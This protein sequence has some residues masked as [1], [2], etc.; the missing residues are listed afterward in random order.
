MHSAKKIIVI[1]GGIGGAAAAVSL[2][3][4]GFEPVVYER[5]K[6]LREV[7]AGIA[8]WANATHVLKKLDLLE[9]ALRVG[10]VTSNYQFNSQSGKELVNVPVDG[11][12][13]PTIAIHRA[14]LHELLISKIPEK[15]FILGETF[16]QLE[17]QRNKVSARFASGLTIE[18][19][20]LIGADGLKSIVRTEL[21]GEQQ[22]IY[23]N[24]TTWRGLTSH[25]PNTYRSG[26]IREFLGRGKEFGFMMLGKNR[27]YWYAAALARENQL[28][29]TVGRKKEL[30]DMFQ[31]WFASIPEL[32]AATD[33]ADIIKTNL[34]DRIPALP[35]SKQNITLLGDAAHPTLPT[36]GQGACMALEDAVVVTKCLL[37]NSEAAVAFREYESVRFERTKYIV[38]QSLRSAQMGKLQHPIQVALRETLMKLIKPVI[39]NSFKSLHGYRA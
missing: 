8:L 13:L 31:D 3:R 19:D 29:A 11:F 37:E 16:E 20:A 4:N 9:S 23:R 2:H 38:K 18:G 34:Y 25:T 1:G 35:W 22:P 5:V 10:V 14:D 28:D 26:Y 30:E 24:F 36:L 7:G 32:I 27:M 15:E 39:K 6:E 21:F 17:L 12:E 33:E